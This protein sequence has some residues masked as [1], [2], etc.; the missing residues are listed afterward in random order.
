MFAQR[1][2]PRT[3][4]CFH[5]Q[6]W[7]ATLRLAWRLVS[8]DSRAVSLPLS[9]RILRGFGAFLARI[10]YRVTPHDAERLPEG[11]FLLLPNHLTWVDAIVLQLGCPRPIRFIIFDAIYRQPLLYPIFRCVGAIPI[12]PKHAKDAVRTA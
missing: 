12:S 3:L 8:K 11:G 6:R 1:G 10:L 5:R 4:A 9:E 2:R 7:M